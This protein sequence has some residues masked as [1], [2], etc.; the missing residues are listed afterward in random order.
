VGTASVA[1]GVAD[2]QATKKPL[3]RTRMTANVK[4]LILEFIIKLLQWFY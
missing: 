2:P 3:A 1:A 4:I